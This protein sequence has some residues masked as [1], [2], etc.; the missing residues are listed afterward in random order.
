MRLYAAIIVLVLV[1]SCG[2][3]KKSTTPDVANKAPQA[4]PNRKP[5]AAS[6]PGAHHAQK[7]SKPLRKRELKQKYA[8]ILKTTPGKIKNRRLYY[9]I[10]DWYGVTY[11]WGGNTQSGVDCSGLVCQLYKDVYGVKVKRTVATQHQETRNF[12]RMRRLREGDFVYF[13]TEGNKLNHVGIYL[14]NGYFVHASQSK[15]VA[16]NNL[17]EDFWQRVYAGGGKVKKKK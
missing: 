2:S 9:F 3:A 13:R 10:D 14:R 11:K 1:T 8:S 5:V 7:L 16:I 12:K 17:E 15:G 4:S 6:N